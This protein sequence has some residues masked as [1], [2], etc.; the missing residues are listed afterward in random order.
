MIHHRCIVSTFRNGEN[1]DDS[2]LNE[3][4]QPGAES[5]PLNQSQE[6]LAME[7]LVGMIYSDPDWSRRQP[8][9]RYQ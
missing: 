5:T 4:G 9:S 7:I 1:E 8:E 2:S 6:D 3:A